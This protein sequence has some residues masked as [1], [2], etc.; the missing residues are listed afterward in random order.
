MFYF[1]N[2]S[3]HIAVQPSSSVELR[4]EITGAG[5]VAISSTGPTSIHFKNTGSMLFIGYPKAHI[6]FVQHKELEALYHSSFS[7]RYFEYFSPT[8]CQEIHLIQ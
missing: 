4:R 2:S 5:A 8:L 1:H 3:T 6:M 7:L